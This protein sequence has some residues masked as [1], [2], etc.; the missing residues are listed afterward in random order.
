ML[1]IATKTHLDVPRTSA[2]LAWL[3]ASASGLSGLRNVLRGPVRALPAYLAFG[4]MYWLS[5]PALG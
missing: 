1:L 5:W 4:V 3:V 2:S